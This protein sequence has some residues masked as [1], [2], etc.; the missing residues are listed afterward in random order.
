VLEAGAL[1]C[2]CAVGRAC[3]VAGRSWT[4]CSVA[5]AMMGF[6]ALVALELEKGHMLVI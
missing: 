6:G 3:P 4:S 2:D 1:Y 5:G